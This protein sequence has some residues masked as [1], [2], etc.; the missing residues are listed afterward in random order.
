MVWGTWLLKALDDVYGNLAHTRSSA[1]L[2]G[3]VSEASLFKKNISY[4]ILWSSVYIAI[5]RL[6][7]GRM[8][9]LSKVFS[10]AWVCLGFVL[11][12]LSV[13]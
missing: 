5:T 7:L 11:T 13:G 12:K 2:G 10:D 4:Y 6:C 8:L 3:S 1:K 9:T